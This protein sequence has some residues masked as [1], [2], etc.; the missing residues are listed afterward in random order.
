MRVDFKLKN[1]G[2]KDSYNTSYQIVIQKELTYISH[3]DGLKEVSVEKDSEGNTV[4]TFDLQAPI[5]KGENYGSYI[6]LR[7][8][9]CVESVSNLNPEEYNNLPDELKITKESS[10]ILDL[11][12]TRG[13]KQVTQY[14]RTPL[15]F[16]YRKL[17]GSLVYLDMILTGRRSNPT[18]EIK[19][20]I[21]LENNDTL[22]DIKLKIN[23]VDYTKYSSKNL[24]NLDELGIIVYEGNYSNYIDESPNE[25]EISN[26]EH[27]ITYIVQMQRRDK[28]FTSNRI[29]YN[30][31][32]IGLSIYELIVIIVSIV[33][34]ALALI[35]LILGIKNLKSYKGDN[36]EKEVQNVDTGKLIE[37]E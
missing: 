20:K 19:P 11:N 7:Y 2:D 9:K 35:F 32:D 10:A 23:K 28:S 26:K 37:E 36:L 25:K 16:P 1:V 24:R 34:I 12:P 6:F 22:N 13:V 33:F 30:Q 31:K 27:S 3:Y 4:I 14:L 21:K 18:I 15:S 8:Y 29:K 17:T 5:N